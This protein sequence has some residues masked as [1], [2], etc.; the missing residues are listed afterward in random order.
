MA[1]KQRRQFRWIKVWL[2][3]A[4]VI[5]VLGVIGQIITVI[6]PPPVPGWDDL[7]LCSYVGSLDG[8]KILMLDENHHVRFE[9]ENNQKDSNDGDKNKIIDGEWSFDEGTKR[10]AITLNGATT[11]YSVVQWDNSNTCL[12]ING[13]LNSANLRESWFSQNV[14]V[15]YDTRDRD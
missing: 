14:E 9:D 11:I 15:P 7:S 12:L 10:Y 8:A 1:R 13:D 3:F 6:S 4:G 5:V 2:T